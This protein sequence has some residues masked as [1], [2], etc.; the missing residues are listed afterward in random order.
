[1]A[2]LSRALSTVAIALRPAAAL[3]SSRTFEKLNGVDIAA[4][5]LAE[6]VERRNLS[7]G[8]TRDGTG[9]ADE[10]RAREADRSQPDLGIGK[11]C[12]EEDRERV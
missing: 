9:D 2:R 12:D 7:P 8:Q 1:M 10:A 5:I 4:L 3:A 6:N 11:S